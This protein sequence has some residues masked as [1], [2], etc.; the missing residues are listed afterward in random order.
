[1]QKNIRTSQFE[2]VALMASLMSVV[3][4]AI[5]ALLPAL[6]IIG[7]TIGTTNVVDNQLLITM[8]FLGLGFGPLVFGPLSDGLGRKP[9]VYMGFALFIGASFICVNATSLEMMVIGRILQGIGLSA[10]RTISIAIIR[11]MYSGDYMARIMSFVTVVFILVPV[12]A[13]ALGKF[14]LDYY[15][16]H[17]I[18]YIQVI[19][20]LVVSFWF[21]KRQPETLSVENKKVFSKKGFIGEFKELLKFK[22]T[23]GFTV[24]SG[25]IT[26]SFMVYL[27]SSQQIFQNQY[28]LKE[29]FP[30]IFAGL[31]IA[32]GAAVFSNGVLVL[33]YGMEK[34]IT[35]A[36]VSFFV[37]SASYVALFYNTPN[38]DVRILLLF[39]ALQFFSIGFLFGNVRAMAMEPV[40]H[41]AG[42]AAAVT[43]FISTIMAVP[44]SIFIG[45][46]IKETALPLFVGFS[47]CSALAV[48]LLFYLKMDEKRRIANL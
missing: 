40:G 31:A 12:V 13:P 16:W 17:G 33:K 43:G 3:A 4:L 10:P 1:M 34:L 47:I 9:I 38:P 19:I 23:I 32:I 36:L 26:G 14:V 22:K 11:D 39:F 28:E 41:I 21:W 5:D 35:V 25:F 44:I 6:E 48:G 46:F 45:R 8:I 37:V 29:E 30:Y 27:S 7:I 15:N 24:I 2:F 42:I 18:F 20:S